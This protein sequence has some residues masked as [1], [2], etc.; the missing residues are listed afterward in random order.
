MISSRL[1]A[2]VFTFFLFQNAFADPAKDMDFNS[3]LKFLSA[4]KGKTR[5]L[6]I[7]APPELKYQRI[8]TEVLDESLHEQHNV[9]ILSM[10]SDTTQMM[11]AASERSIFNA[12]TRGKKTIVIQVVSQLDFNAPSFQQEPGVR[13][14]VYQPAQ[15]GEAVLKEATVKGY[16]KYIHDRVNAT[17]HDLVSLFLYN[18]ANQGLADLEIIDFNGSTPG[19]LLSFELLNLI[20]YRGR[21]EISRI[22]FR[23]LEL[24]IQ[25]TMNN[26]RLNGELYSLYNARS[27]IQS[28]FLAHAL[29]LSAF[30]KVDMVFN[31]YEARNTEESPYSLQSWHSGSIKFS[32]LDARYPFFVKEG[33]VVIEERN[34]QLTYNGLMVTV[35]RM[36]DIINAIG[37]ESVLG[38]I[39]N[40][41]TVD[42][43]KFSAE[44]AWERLL[45]YAL[46][47]TATEI[48][49]LEQTP[50]SAVENRHRLAVLKESLMQSLSMQPY[51]SN[52][53]LQYLF[54]L[55]VNGRGIYVDEAHDGTQ[56][57]KEMPT[58]CK[59]L[60]PGKNSGLGY[61]N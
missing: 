34:Q 7:K 32:R 28:F 30:Q 53:D 49:H 19:A 33:Q 6:C 11:Q 41:Y 46:I 15:W 5:M 56:D 27:H 16:D 10:D 40:R 18:V 23:W 37:T 12:A 9:V 25:D 42:K 26:H 1:L 20:R 55:Y 31:S 22:Q 44:L 21:K 24:A 29:D 17:G 48:R 3:I 52:V 47:G 61:R 50:D 38:E 60:I 13:Y 2:I 14:V 8:L 58:N 4:Q 59:V 51:D 39:R 36:P 45:P 43:E 57:D 35:Q 54:Y